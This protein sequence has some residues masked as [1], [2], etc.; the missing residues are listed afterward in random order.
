MRGRRGRRRRGRVRSSHKRVFEVFDY[1]VEDEEEQEKEG[2]KD[3]N[4]E[5]GV[6][7]GDKDEVQIDRKGVNLPIREVEV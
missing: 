1:E 2:I 6:D 5:G 7:G 4:E 3:K